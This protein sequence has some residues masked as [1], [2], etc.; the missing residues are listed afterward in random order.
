MTPPHFFQLA[1][2]ALSIRPFPSKCLGVSGNIPHAMMTK[3]REE[4]MMAT[5]QR[6]LKDVK[7]YPTMYMVEIPVVTANWLQ[8]PSIPRICGGAISIM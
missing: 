5:K 3:S 4:G 7:K 1:Y 2:L 6:L 8:E